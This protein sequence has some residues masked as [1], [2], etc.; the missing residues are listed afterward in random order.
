ME[1]NRNPCDKPNTSINQV[2]LD[3]DTETYIGEKDSLLNNW[4]W[5]NCIYTYRKLK[6]DPYLSSCKKSTQNRS[7]NIMLRP[8]ILKLL[9]KT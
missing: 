4:C 6:H 3:K 8:G 1:Q 2:I 7:K 9:K 5:K